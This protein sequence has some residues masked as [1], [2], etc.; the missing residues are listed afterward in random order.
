MKRSVLFASVLVFFFVVKHSDATEYRRNL[1]TTSD[2]S[3]T[4][5]KVNRNDRRYKVRIVANV[6]SPATTKE[7][8]I[9]F[10][11]NGSDQTGPKHGSFYNSFNSVYGVLAAYLVIIFC[12]C[13]CLLGIFL[14]LK[15]SRL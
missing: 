5:N 11:E 3:A 7:P 15:C 4:S 1:E 8:E 10:P 14:F 6:N 13:L 12:L 2:S 9:R